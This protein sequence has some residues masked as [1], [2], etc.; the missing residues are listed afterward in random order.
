MGTA[1]AGLLILSVMLTG[2]FMFWRVDLLGNDLFGNAK[3][4][5]TK[6]QGEQVRTI[7]SITTAAANRNNNTLAMSVKNDGATS[8]GVSEFPKMDLI[9]IFDGAV[10]APLRLSYTESSPPPAGQWTNTAISGQF[11]SNVWNPEETLTID[12]TLVGT[13]CDKGTVTIGTPKGVYD[14][15]PF[16]CAGLDLYF[17]SE[18]TTITPT[19]YYQLKNNTPADGV[20]TTI[21]AAF[22]AGVTGRVNPTSNSGKF[23]FPLTGITRIPAGT[24]NITYRAKR[25]ITDFG[26]WF[27]F[28]GVPSGVPDISLA[29][30]T[31]GWQNIDLTSHVPTTAT[32]AIVEIVNS[33]NSN[34]RGMV[35]GKEDTNTYNVP[36]TSPWQ[37]IEA[38]THRYQIVK[39]DSS[40]DIEGFIS[41]LAVDFHLLGYTRGSDPTFFTTPIDITPPGIDQWTS[42]SVAQHVDADTTGVILLV[43][44]IADNSDDYGIAEVS[45]DASEAEMEDYG[46]GMWLVGLNE[47]DQFKVWLEDLSTFKLYLVGQTKGSV[48]YFCLDIFTADPSPLNSWQ[49]MDADDYGIPAA[50]NGL[51]FRVYNDDNPAHYKIGFRHGDNTTDN[52]NN[53]IADDSHFQG[54]AGLNAANQWYEYKEEEDVW[55]YV[56]AFTRLVQMDVHA[57]ID[58]RLRKADD[59]ERVVSGKFPILDVANTSNITSDTWQTFTASFTM[60]EYTVENQ[61]DYLEIDLFAQATSNISTENVSLQFRID[62]PALAL[63]DQMR[64]TEV[65]P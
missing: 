49:L 19:T 6:L 36:P 5:A 55:V 54:A 3:K 43:D 44:N 1:L 52:W 10:Q 25:D 21:S 61:T 32:G 50:A 12:A 18:T 53:D 13:V 24:W 33:G 38:R 37:K 7:L 35:K 47:F 60:P 28:D 58:V 31:G 40:Q 26:G 42:V 11:E 56:A 51:I 39:L 2:A 65:V 64:A 20:A 34:H 27:W 9:V 59:T 15:K 4:A 8:V 30:V 29:S 14:T 23:V 63:A 62:D 16:I 22:A 41:N 57:E 46:N 17:H 48:V 45:C